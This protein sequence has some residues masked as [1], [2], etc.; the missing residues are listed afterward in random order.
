MPPT[1]QSVHTPSR[2]PSAVVE[3]DH[4]AKSY[5]A[6]RAV[7]DVS[8]AV[9]DGEIFG[10][11]GPNGSGKTTTV[12]CVSGLRRRDGGTVRVL[13]LDPLRDR[14]AIRS[15]VGVQ[16]QEAELPAKL[17]VREALALYA[18]FYPS[19][20][21]W[22][23]L[24]DVLGLGPS[25]RTRF[26]SLSGGQQQRLSIALALVGNPRVAILDE[27][28][29][30]LDPA[31]RRETWDLVERVRE[32]GVTVLLV[33]H[34]MQEAERL[35]DRLAVIDAGRVV[36]VDTPAGLVDRLGTRQELRFRPSQPFD[37]SL[38]ARLDPVADVVR[39]GAELR[40]AGTGDVLGAVVSAL[41][42]AGVVAEGLRV[43]QPDLDD[44]FLALVGGHDPLATPDPVTTTTTTQERP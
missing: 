22:R 18:S 41:A 34:F 26:G 11:L 6:T 12:E 31:A 32:R 28:T 10:I 36:A 19:P 37:E 43:L 9:D 23:E 2:P 7:V 17:T 5:G 38:L 39:R 33:T 8:L 20:A 24:V 44:A 30:G 13:G 42:R 16:L 25:L 4:L 27:L 40:V 29:T 3:I 15:Q 1:P 14:A 35:C 21:D